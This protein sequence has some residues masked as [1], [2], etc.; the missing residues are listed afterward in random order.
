MRLTNALTSSWLTRALGPVPFTCARSTPISRASL[1]TEGLAYAFEKPSSLN[2][3]STLGLRTIG[4]SRAG[5]SLG[6]SGAAADAGAG[7]GAGAG[8]G[9]A[10]GVGAEAGAGGGCTA[11]SLGA[12]G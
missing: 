11:A 8:E 2:T 5:G 1:R 4:A 3:G 6:G 9:P 10:A 12:A 7:A